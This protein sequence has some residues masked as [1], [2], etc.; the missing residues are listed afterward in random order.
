MGKRHTRD[1]RGKQTCYQ[2]DFV[3]LLETGDIKFDYSING[4]IKQENSSFVLQ[5]IDL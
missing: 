4:E 2:V 5:K 1:Q 3:G